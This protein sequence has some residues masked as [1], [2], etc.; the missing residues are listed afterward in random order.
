MRCPCEHTPEAGPSTHHGVIHLSTC[1]HSTLERTTRPYR[2]PVRVRKIL[3]TKRVI[4]IEEEDVA[5]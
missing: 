2:G 1:R 4:R 3:G 5:A